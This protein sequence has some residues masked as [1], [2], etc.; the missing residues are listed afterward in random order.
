M[1]T[2]LVSILFV[3]VLRTQPTIAGTVFR[4]IAFITS[5][6]TN[7][8]LR[9][10]LFVKKKITKTNLHTAVITMRSESHIIQISQAQNLICPRKT[11][12]TKFTTQ[13]R[14]ALSLNLQLACDTV[15][16]WVRLTLYQAA[17]IT[18][19]VVLDDF[20]ATVASHLQLGAGCGHRTRN[21]TKMKGLFALLVGC[22]LG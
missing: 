7:H 16:A 11:Y 18:F 10:E 8:S 15:T 4:N 1:F 5:L 9:L 20:I 21:E 22:R 19:L 2:T 14:G 12:F 13:S 3:D 17:T 6:A